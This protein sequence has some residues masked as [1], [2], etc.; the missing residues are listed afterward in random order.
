MFPHFFASVFT[1]HR[2]VSKMLKSIN[3]PAITGVF[4]A[5]CS[6]EFLIFG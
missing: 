3:P 2:G 5:K 4:G 1:K 6:I